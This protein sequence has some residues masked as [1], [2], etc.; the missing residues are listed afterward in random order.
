MEQVLYNSYRADSINVEA[1]DALRIPEA[2]I[3]MSIVD[4]PLVKSN[5]EMTRDMIWRNIR[6]TFERLNIKVYIFNDRFETR[7]YIPTEIIPIPHE[8][9][10]RKRE[11]IICSTKGCGQHYRTGGE[12]KKRMQKCH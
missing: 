1:P 3:V 4:G 12:V 8:V 2:G 5:F 7:G 10:S 9:R 11:A 6:E